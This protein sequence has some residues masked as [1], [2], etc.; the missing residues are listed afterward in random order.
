MSTAIQDHF[1]NQKVTTVDSHIA[2]VWSVRNSEL[3]IREF[4]KS[5]PFRP[6]KIINCAGLTDPKLPKQT[7]NDV[8]FELPKNLLNI[9]QSEDIELITF[10][11]I[12]EK[13]PALCEE[14]PYLMSKEMY[15]RHFRQ[16]VSSN[17]RQSHLQLHTLY[18]GKKIHSHMFLGQMFQ[19]I[20]KGID[21]KMT[22]GLQLREYHHIADDIQAL[23]RIMKAEKYG[24]IEISHNEK[25]SLRSIAEFVFSEFNIMSR[26]KIGELPSPEVEQYVLEFNHFSHKPLSGFRPSLT[27]ITEYL[28]ELLGKPN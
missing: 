22:A 9:S 1:R 10:G 7:L 11:S 18:G 17:S 19:A 2:K 21:F 27:G 14:N 15:F 20:Q 28:R 16:S 13:N 12:L 8:N 24:V 25:L 6:T 23:E 5:L 4:L 26:L 3:K